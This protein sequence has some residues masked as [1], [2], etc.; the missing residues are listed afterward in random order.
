MMKK[1]ERS[2]FT[3]SRSVRAIAGAVLAWGIAVDPAWPAAAGQAPL[4]TATVMAPLEIPRQISMERF[5]QLLDEAKKVGVDSVSVDVW[6][7]MVEKSGDQQFDWSYYDQ[8]FEKIRARQLK[9]VP[10]LSFHKCG[11]GPGDDCF[12]PPPPWLYG[13]FATAGLGA[14][15]LKFESE[16]GRL[17]DDAIPPWATAIPAVLDQ[18]REFM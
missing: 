8:I 14:N 4:E 7:G 6:W 11:A 13:H 1:S 17:Q 3:A 10:I 2:V 15:D 5:E 18:F 9:I 16:T 12:V